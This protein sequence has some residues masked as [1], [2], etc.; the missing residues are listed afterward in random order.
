M[1]NEKL[2]VIND[3]RSYLLGVN[4][5]EVLSYGTKAHHLCAVR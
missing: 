4:L 3:Y 1:I 5:A 2:I